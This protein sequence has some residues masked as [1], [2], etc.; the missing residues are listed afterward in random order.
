M[1]GRRS[2]SRSPHQ[3]AAKASSAPSTVPPA[4][5]QGDGAQANSNTRRAIAP[6]RIMAAAEARKPA[7]APTPSNSLRCTARSRPLLAPTARITAYSRARF[8]RVAATAA[9]STTSPAA[10]VKPNKN[11]TARITW[12]S[13]FCTCASE[14]ETSTLVMLGNWRTKLASKWVF[15]GARNALI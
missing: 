10:S 6:P 5:T 9:N 1:T 11:S 15:T 12:S 14:A 13:T 7:S 4:S 3:P 8:S 2:T